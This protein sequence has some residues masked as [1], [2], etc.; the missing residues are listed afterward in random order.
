MSNSQR[1]HCSRGQSWT[2]CCDVRGRVYAALVLHSLP[3]T[4]L[5]RK[6]PFA[7]AWMIFKEHERTGKP[8]T[9]TTLQQ[10]M[11]KAIQVG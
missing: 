4:V 7:A 10:L 5:S 11:S 9:Y 3:I 6:G 2:A 8:L 1:Q